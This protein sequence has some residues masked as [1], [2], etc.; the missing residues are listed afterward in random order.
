MHL[1]IDFS[2][3]R[4]EEKMLFVPINGSF[5]LH[6]VFIIKDNQLKFDILGRPCRRQLFNNYGKLLVGHVIC[7]VTI[8]PQNISKTLEDELI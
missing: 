7:R 5:I 6:D 3:L 1:E 4:G 2:N 8:F